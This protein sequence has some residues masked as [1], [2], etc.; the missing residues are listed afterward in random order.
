MDVVYTFG[1][2]Y[3]GWGHSARLTMEIKCVSQ[4]CMMSAAWHRM[5]IVVLISEFLENEHSNY[6]RVCCVQTAVIGPG[7]MY[8]ECWVV[9][10]IE[11]AMLD[12]AVEAHL[13]VEQNEF[14]REMRREREREREG[15]RERERDQ[16]HVNARSIVV[17]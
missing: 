13:A 15:E 12:E 9:P 3:C 5:V 10:M 17:M 4:S 6:L 1:S 7:P 16:L 11:E 2:K 8:F 14:H